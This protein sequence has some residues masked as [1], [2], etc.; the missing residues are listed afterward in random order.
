MRLR[1][2]LIKN[3]LKKGLRP[4]YLITGDE[5]LQI[6]QAEDLIRAAARSN[7]YTQREVFHAERGFDWNSVLQSAN[8]MSLFAEKKILELRLNSAKLG[9]AGNKMVLKYCESLPPDNLLVISMPKID[10]ATQKTK[11]FK[12]LDQVGAVLQVWP[13][14]IEKLPHWVK[15]QMVS[16]K[17]I[18]SSE[19]VRLICD[20]VEGNL[21]AASQEIEKLALNGPRQID[22]D[23]VLETVADDAKYDVFKLVD[24]VMLGKFSR[25]AKILRGLKASGEEPTV[26]LWALTREIR[27]M[28]S[29]AA[30]K[31]R[32]VPLPQIFKN[33]RVW[34]KRMPI[35]QSGLNRHSE[36]RW[37]L[38]LQSAIRIDKI[39]KG[40]ETGSP[41]D[42]LLDLGFAIANKQ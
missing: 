32:G 23:D 24:A 15:Q 35:V 7:G 30:E 39:I 6:M 9:D 11:W 41:W 25:T 40:A 31:K 33:Y 28:I 34:D 29:M 10:A 14:E 38:L 36:A 22:V 4:V 8:S 12:Q 21:L 3:D 16:R 27:S 2:D 26:I 17:I 5:P 13:V 37:L 1:F 42:E 20:K 19:A 18:P